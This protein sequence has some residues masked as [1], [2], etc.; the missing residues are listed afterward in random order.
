MPKRMRMLALG[1]QLPP[2]ANYLP[3]ELVL[4]V[5]NRHQQLAWQ[6]YAGHVDH[7]LAFNPMFASLTIAHATPQ[8]FWSGISLTD[9]EAFMRSHVPANM[10][11]EVERGMQSAKMRLRRREILVR[12]TDA[13]L[14][15]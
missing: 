1:N 9:L 7:L 8:I 10:A 11:P 12:E 13:W 5:A 3:L 2:Q 14:H 4:G 15:R 6:A